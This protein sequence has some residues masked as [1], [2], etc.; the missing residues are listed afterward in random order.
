MLV[1]F[2]NSKAFPFHS[3]SVIVPTTRGALLLVVFL[4]NVGGDTVKLVIC[5]LKISTS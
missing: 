3:L 1:F 2:F 5:P 4:L